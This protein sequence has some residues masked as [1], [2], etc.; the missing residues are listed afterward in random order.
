MLVLAPSLL[1]RYRKEREGFLI[2]CINHRGE[3]LTV[4]TQLGLNQRTVFGRNGLLAKTTLV[5]G[6]VDFQRHLEGAP[7]EVFRLTV[8]GKGRK[9]VGRAF[10]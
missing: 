5:R 1:L 9:M 2:G 8:K 10:G 4:C 3:R 7:G 6:P